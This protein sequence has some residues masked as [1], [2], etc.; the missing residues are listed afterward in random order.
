[1]D[2]FNNDNIDP[3]VVNGFGDEWSRFDQSGLSEREHCLMFDAY[4][5]IF[6]WDKLLPDSKGFD[7]GCGS[8]RWAKLV[9][10]RVGEPHCIDLSNAA[11]DV[12]KRN[13]IHCRNCY[14]HLTDVDNMPLDDG[15]ADF[16]YS[17]GVLHH[18]PNT[19]AG[20]RNCVAKLK[21]GAPFLLY[22]SHAPL[23]LFDIL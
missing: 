8:G 12:A 11:L 23:T 17:L 10:P 4:F 9:A 18:I 1:M 6:P 21:Q 5:S 14:F 13:L 16:G 22:L 15:S 20:L 2:K 3:E 19:A 7:M